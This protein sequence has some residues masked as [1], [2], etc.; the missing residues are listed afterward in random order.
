MMVSMGCV[1]KLVRVASLVM[2][3]LSSYN[4][5]LIPY[6]KMS[7]TDLTNVEPDQEATIIAK[8]LDNIEPSPSAGTSWYV[9]SRVWWDK[10][11]GYVKNSAKNEAPGPIDASDILLPEDEYTMD[12][13]T[14]DAYDNNVLKKGI[15]AE[16]DFK[17]V[18]K[19]VWS[20]LK[21]KYGLSDPRSEVKRYSIEVSEFMTQVE[22]SLRPNKFVWV[23]PLAAGPADVS[24]VRTIHVSRK[25]DLKTVKGKIFNIYNESVSR[26]KQL[27]MKSEIRLWKLK[28]ELSVAQFTEFV[29]QNDRTDQE[30]IKPEFPGD[31]LDDYDCLEEI[32]MAYD[33]I[34]VAEIKSDATKSWRFKYDEF[35][36]YGVSGAS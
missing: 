12:T 5:F 23:T 11:D 35:P 8:L 4:T 3:I 29:S 26:S 10:W 6:I 25:K 20:A 30:N 34:F 33:D 31:K 32:E 2:L 36:T 16:N 9:V 28:S 21:N 22:V 27:Y 7:F 13:T 15:R 18:T 19:Q 1:Q 17:I 14:P 24:E